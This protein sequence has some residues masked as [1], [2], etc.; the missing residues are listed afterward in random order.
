MRAMGSYLW[1]K[2]PTSARNRE[3]E[4]KIVPK[5]P[6][7]G[8]FG[9]NIGGE[10]RQHSVLDLLGVAEPSVAQLLAG[11]VDEDR[12]EGRL[13][14]G[15]VTDGEAAPLGRGHHLR[16]DTGGSPDVQQDGRIHSL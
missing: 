5:G 8:L 3:P 15:E 12:L 14:D 6:V 7:S 2:V 4:G 13:G 16:Q 9:T 10:R 1:A 11:Q